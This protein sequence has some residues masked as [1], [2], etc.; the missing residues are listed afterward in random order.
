M[1]EL[2]HLGEPAAGRAAGRLVEVAVDA[3]GG[4]GARTYTYEL[5]AALAGVAPGEAVLVPF[6]KGGRQV[7]G[8]VTGE[9]RRTDGLAVRPVAARV[10]PH[11]FGVDRHRALV[12]GKV[13]QIA[14]VQADG[15]AIVRF[16]TGIL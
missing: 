2:D 3:P 14:A 8:V 6:G 11:G 13:R 12:G 15:H 4:T 7:L 9:G 16:A 5:P 10:E 1:L